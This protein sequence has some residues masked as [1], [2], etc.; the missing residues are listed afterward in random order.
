MNELLEGGC[1]CGAVR[2][3]MSGPEAYYDSKKLW[4]P[5]SLARRNAVFG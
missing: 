2:Y 4:P 1:A 3:R 5:D